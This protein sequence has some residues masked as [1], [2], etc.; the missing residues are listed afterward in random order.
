M[1]ETAERLSPTNLQLR[2]LTEMQ[3]GLATCVKPIA[4]APKWR[5]TA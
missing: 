4:M 5:P 1:I 3:N 2:Y